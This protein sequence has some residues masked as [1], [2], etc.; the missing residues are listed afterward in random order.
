MKELKGAS[1]IM[2]TRQ[3]PAQKANIERL[4]AESAARMAKL[5]VE[6]EQARADQE[7]KAA[8]NAEFQARVKATRTA[9][10]NGQPLPSEAKVVT[11][12]DHY[13]A[14]AEAE[15]LAA[16]QAEAARVAALTPRDLWMSTRTWQQRKQIAAWEGVNK[17]P[18][19]MELAQ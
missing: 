11:M 9:F 7:A 19:P 17:M 12:N 5:K 2:Y 15:K 1:P 13:A 18:Y 6:Q 3:T 8:T 4:N 14:K 16:E 10:A